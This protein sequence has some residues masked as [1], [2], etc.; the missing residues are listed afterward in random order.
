MFMNFILLILAKKNNV[1]GN[2]L[3]VKNIN[4]LF[5]YS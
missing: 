3:A 4:Y 5:L 2:P 1:E